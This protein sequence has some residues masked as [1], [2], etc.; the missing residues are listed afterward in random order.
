MRNTLILFVMIQFFCSEVNAQKLNNAK[1]LGKWQF[2]QITLVSPKQGYI[3]SFE[4]QEA[5]LMRMSMTNYTFNE[6]GSALL[7]EEYTKKTGITK[8]TWKLNADQ[9]GLDIT[10]QFSEES[11]KKDETLP[12]KVETVTATDLSLKLQKMFIVRFKKVVK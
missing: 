7:T 8:A 10:Y 3:P 2:V 9:T 4:T 1:I 11:G 5:N 12:W 6:D